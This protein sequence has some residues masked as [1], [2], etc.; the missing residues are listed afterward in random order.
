[1]LAVLDAPPQ[2]HSHLR[3]ACA[4]GVP[5]GDVEQVLSSVEEFMSE[6]AIERTRSTW[7][8]VRSRC[9]SIE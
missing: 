8:K 7:K 1:L 3:G 9:S 4:V 2:L 5:P 6:G